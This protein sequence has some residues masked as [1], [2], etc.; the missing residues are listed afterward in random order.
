MKREAITDDEVR[1]RE[2]QSVIQVFYV[3]LIVKVAC[4]GTRSC[5]DG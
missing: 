1:K 5:K 2:V 4:F 3:F